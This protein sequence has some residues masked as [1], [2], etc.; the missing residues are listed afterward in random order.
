MFVCVVKCGMITIGKF[1]IFEVVSE[2]YDKLPV[3]LF[4]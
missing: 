2:N 1:M 4:E 3:I